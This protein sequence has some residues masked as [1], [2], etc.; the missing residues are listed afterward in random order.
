MIAGLMAQ[1][2][3]DF[4]AAALGAYYH[5]KAGEAVTAKIGE[6]ACMAGDLIR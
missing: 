3:D 6:Y 4:H 5:G 1:G 2:M